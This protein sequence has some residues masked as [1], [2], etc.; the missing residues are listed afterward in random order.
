M[1]PV[2]CRVRHD[3]DKGEYG[4]CVRACI[5][6]LLDFDAEEVPHFYHDNDPS[7]GMKR[8]RAF[9]APLGLAPFATHFDGAASLADILSAQAEANPD[10]HYILWGSTEGGN[11]VV[12]A[13]GDKIVHNPSWYPTPL[14]GPLSSGNWAIMV[15]ARL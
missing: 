12:I 9:L 3:P 4:D 5:A 2:F 6:S 15:L 13:K 7:T 8:I 11:H 14:I 10:V 1:T